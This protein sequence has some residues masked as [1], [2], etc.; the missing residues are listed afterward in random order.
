MKDGLRQERAE[1]RQR[2]EKAKR[3]SEVAAKSVNIGKVVE[4]IAPSLPGFPV[5]SSDCRS[6]FEPI[7]YLVFRGLSVAG[8]VEAIDF[9]DVKSG[10]ARLTQQQRAIRSLVAGDRVSLHVAKAPISEKEEVQP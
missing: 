10:A 7:D 4:K 2:V 3:R 9:V 5:R 6:L 8:V 1:F